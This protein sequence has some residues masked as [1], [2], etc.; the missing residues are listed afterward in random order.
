MTLPQHLLLYGIVAIIVFLGCV[1]LHFR[2]FGNRDLNL[3]I[4]VLVIGGLGVGT[5]VIVFIA[6]LLLAIW[7]CIQ[8]AF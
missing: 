3:N 7:N 2:F 6:G 1:V 5:G 4:A 8:Q